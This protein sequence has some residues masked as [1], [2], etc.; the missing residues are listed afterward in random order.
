M[1]TARLAGLIVALAATACGAA[2]AADEWPTRPIRVVASISAGTSLDT[3]ARITA[4]YLSAKLGQKVYVENHPGASGNIASDLVARAAPDGYTLLFTSNVITTA[5]AFLGPRAVDPPAALAPISIVASQPL[6]IVAHP[7]FAGTGFADLVTMARAKPREL[8]YATSGV[9]SLAHLTALWAQSRAG[10]TMLHVPY[11][12]SQSFRDVV[13]GEVPFGFTLFASALPL[14]RKGQL[15][16]IAITAAERSPL[17]PDIPTLRA[18]GL[19][20]FIVTN[21][22]G[23]L[24]PA[25]TPAHV[26]A[27]LHAEVAGMARDKEIDA[28]LRDMG[29]APVFNTPAQF[30]QEIREET[31][32]WTAIVKAADLRLD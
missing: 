6:I 23:L 17:A 27:R 19:P 9:G 16:A 32:R 8:A 4:D 29:Y 25:G 20:E 26:V 22:Q 15:K 7:S 12:T 14:V 1:I 21:W 2:H 31:R 13:S 24:A 30:S 5:P 18:S 10:I 3:L 28:R 11:A